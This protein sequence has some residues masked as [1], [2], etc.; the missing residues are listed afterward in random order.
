MNGF[1]LGHVFGALSDYRPVG[2]EPVL[3]TIVTDSREAR[4]GALFVALAGERHDGHDY[5]ADAFQRGAI[6]A[7]VNRPVLES[8]NMIRP[9]SNQPLFALTQAILPLQIVVADPLAALQQVAAYWRAN[10]KARVIGITGSV[11]KTSTKEVVAAVLA[12]RFCTLKSEGNFNNELGLPLT[13]LQLRPEHERAVL[14]M[15]MYARGEIALLCGL[16]RPEVGVVTNV[17]PV[18]LSRLGSL[19]A[20][21]AAKQELVE[22]LPAGGVAILNHDDPLVMGMAAA[23]QAT[24]FTYGLDPQANLWADQIKSMGLNGIRFVAHYQQEQ[25]HIQVPL[26]GR[27]SVHTCLRAIAVGLVEGLAW[28]EIITGLQ[29][30]ATQLRLVTARGPHNSLI[31]DDT[32][33]ASPESVIAALNLLYDLPGRKVAVLG[34]MLELGSAETAGHQLVGQ[35]AAGVA[36]LLLAIGPRGRI[37][38]E[39]AKQAGLEQVIILDEAQQAIPI[40]EELVTAGDVILVKGSRG[41]ALD[42]IVAALSRAGGNP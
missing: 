25:L 26:L 17:G 39:T 15:G 38:G 24:I 14:E 1:S 3:S 31:L 35:R 13:L 40:L 8:G 42:R 4:P 9:G 12:Q 18:H 27:H 5:L 30:Q 22:S 6:A 36:H 23:S 37:I 16:A 34:D 41:V 11:G 33:N 29:N 28:E 21:V 2:N 7:L 10:M 20:I 19:E 32:Y